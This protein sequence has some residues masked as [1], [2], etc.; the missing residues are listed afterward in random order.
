MASSDPPRDGVELDAMAR[1]F[2]NAM[3]RA[4]T[5]LAAMNRA[6]DEL[7]GLAGGGGARLRDAESE[8]RRRL[9]GDLAVEVGGARI[10]GAERPL[11]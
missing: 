9:L 6:A 5:R 8:A 1:R 7:A 11:S 2:D 4:R 10:P 3:D